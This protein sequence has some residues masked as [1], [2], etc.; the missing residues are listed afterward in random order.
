M[1]KLKLLVL[2][3]VCIGFA[4]AQTADSTAKRNKF[5]DSLMIKTPYFGIKFGGFLRHDAAFDSRQVIGA[6][7]SSVLLWP[8]DVV[9]DVDG[10]DINAAP[11]FQMLA[12]ISR[13]SGT[14][15]GPDV[16]KA[17]TSGIFEAEFFGNTEASINEFRLRHAWIK[18]DWKKTQL[19]LGQYWNPM[20]VM[21][22]YAGVVNFNTGAPF[23]PFN[24]NPQIRLTQKLGT[25]FNM[26]VAA[27]SQRDFSSN[28][29][30]YRNSALPAGHLQFQFKTAKF[31]AGIAGH[32]ENLRPK[33][34]GT[35]APGVVKVSN[36][37]VTSLSSIA[38]AK[39]ITKPVMIRAEA[40]VGQNASTFVM[41]G[42]FVGYT[43]PGGL[44]TYQTMN[45]KSAWIDIVSNNKKIAPGIFFGYTQNDGTGSSVDEA[46]VAT[47]GLSSA[48][49]AVAAGAGKRTI[50]YMYRVSPR[51]EFLFNNFKFGF[52]IECTT[53]QWG[54]AENDGTV[55]NNKVMATN[56]RAL[57][58]TTYT[59]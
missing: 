53:A 19:G 23:M 26:I 3:T 45:T 49:G 50:A 43:L 33:T 36:E 12:I 27:V 47:Y 41:L 46:T 10:K 31:V 21:D 6:R 15:T 29:E 52:E 8:K 30:A 57:F 13:L 22:C 40:F 11:N 4:H 34:S 17:K 7:E 25:K 54:D 2:S 20:T 16:M 42:G 18:L 51:V 55:R 58:A 38:Y 39:I 35:I 59:F 24:R 56:Y 44:E 5:L 14:I 9:R 48:L 37:R 1:K 28:T 32:V